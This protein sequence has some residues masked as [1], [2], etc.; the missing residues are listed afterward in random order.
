MALLDIPGQ[1][2]ISRALL[3]AL[4]HQRLHHAYLFAGPEGVGK[5]ALAQ[6]FAQ[7]I[8]CVDPTPNGD[9]CGQCNV[10]HRIRTQQHA[11]VH[12]IRRAT[13][14]DGQPERFIKIDQVRALQQSLSFKSFEGGKRV[15]LVF[16][17][18]KMNPNTANAMLKTLEEPGENTHF[19]LVSHHAHRLLSTILSRCQRLD[20]APLPIDFVA[21]HLQSEHGADPRQ[22]L[23]I[24][25]LSQGSLIRANR[26]LEADILSLRVTLFDRLHSASA[27]TIGQ[28]ME[29]AEDIS[30][31]PQRDDLNLYF[32]LLR[33][34]YR[35]LLAAMS[36]AAP[37]QLIHQ[38][39]HAGVMRAASLVNSE[40]VSTLIG[41]ITE[42]E[43][44][45]FEHTANAR[46]VVE[47]LLLR[48]TDV[49]FLGVIN[50]R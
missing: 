32:C 18:E 30:R 9:A 28:L 36:G 23:V 44:A 40:T 13:N 7:A 11:D 48:L 5:S 45:I 42:A 34:W 3:R 43:R 33:S 27:G 37:E 25:R 35:D 16:E 19:V 49:G 4:K 41:Q 31:P 1:S 39:L 10:C 6:A 21:E 12:H 2:R 29:W 17:A 24:A 14:R 50:D 15:V 20:F 26:M 8:L 38:D 46:L 22:S 47:S